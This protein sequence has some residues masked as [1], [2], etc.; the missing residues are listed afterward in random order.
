MSFDAD[1][2]KMGKELGKVG[3]SGADFWGFAAVSD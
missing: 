3:V 1:L 2:N